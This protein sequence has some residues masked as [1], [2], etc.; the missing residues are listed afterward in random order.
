M[1]KAAAERVTAASPGHAALQAGLHL[2]REVLL[3]MALGCDDE[4]PSSGHV[5]AELVL[6]LHNLLN[7]LTLLVRGSVVELPLQTRKHELCKAPLAVP[8]LRV[9]PLLPWLRQAS[10]PG[11]APEQRGALRLRDGLFD[12]LQNLRLQVVQGTARLLSRG[13]FLP[14]SGPPRRTPPRRAPVPPRCA[15]RGQEGR[16]RRARSRRDWT[17]PGDPCAAGKDPRAAWLQGREGETQHRQTSD[18]GRL[19]LRHTT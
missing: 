10:S 4:G 2:R 19:L 18:S 12:L 9:H 13:F 16:P 5:I 14:A 11:V 6:D 8:L 17:E 3:R 7:Y 15:W 1:M